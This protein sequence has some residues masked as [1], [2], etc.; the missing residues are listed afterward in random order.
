[1]TGS[2]KIPCSPGDVFT[3]SGWVYTA[4]SGMV[5]RMNI[6]N[7]SASGAGLATIASP[8]VNIT[9]ST[10][11]RLTYTFTV[12]TGVFQF[13]T[14][15][16]VRSSDGSLRNIGDS[17]WMDDAMLERGTSTRAYFD[18]ASKEMGGA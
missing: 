13:Y 17:A 4:L 2:I 9:P 3:F 11:T 1:M 7:Y 15:A 5:A 8:Y 18:G 10:W 6:I 12:P 14:S 16:E